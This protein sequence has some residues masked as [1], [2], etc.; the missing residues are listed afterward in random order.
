MCFLQA[1]VL[2]DASASLLEGFLGVHLIS[3]KYE[4]DGGV[5]L[6]ALE[7]LG[8]E[9]KKVFKVEKKFSLIPALP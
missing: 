1:S 5:G 2:S 4:K 6:T 8:A 7:L 3:C 9:R